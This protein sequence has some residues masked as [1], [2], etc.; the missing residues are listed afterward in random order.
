MPITFRE[1]SWYQNDA[2][3]AAGTRSV[4]DGGQTFLLVDH[5]ARGYQ[6]IQEAAAQ[7]PAGAVVLVAPGTYA[8]QV[9]VEGADGL[10]IRG[11]GAGVVI[12]CPDALTAVRS[13]YWGS[14]VAAVI[15][16]DDSSNVRIFNVTVDGA[17]KGDARPAGSGFAGVFFNNSS[18]ALVDSDVKGVHLQESHFG[19][20]TGMA[21][22]VTNDDEN[23]DNTFSA[24][25]NGFTDFQKAAIV[26]RQANVTISDNEIEGTHTDAIAQNGLDLGYGVTG[27][28]S[29]N[30]ITGIG[31]T[32]IDAS[33]SGIIVTSTATDLAIYGN[34][35]TGVSTTDSFVGIM[36]QT[37]GPGTGISVYGNSIDTAQ[38]GIY[39]IVATNPSAVDTDGPNGD[40]PNQVTNVTSGYTLDTADVPNITTPFE[41][42]GTNGNDSLQGQAGADR[43]NGGAGNDEI[44]GGAGDDVLT[45]G[46]GSDAIDGGGDVD[47]YYLHGPRDGFSFLRLSNGR[48]QVADMSG[49]SADI[50]ILS[51]V[52]R[53]SFNGQVSSLDDLLAE[54]NVLPAQAIDED[55]PWSFVVPRGVFDAAATGF[56]ATLAD[57]S[58]LPAWLSF[59]EATRTFSGTPPRNFNGSVSL[60]VSSEGGDFASSVTFSLSVRPVND[61]PHDITL[62]QGRVEENAGAGT[63]IGTLTGTDVDGGPLTF[64]LV[65]DAGGRFAIQNGRLVVKDSSRLDHEQ[66]TTHTVTIR[67]TDAANASYDETFLIEVGNRINET[68]LGSSSSDILKADAG[69]D[70]ISGAGG[71]D[72]VYGGFGHDS[73]RGDAG[74][75]V[76]VFDTK[77]S[78][79]ANRD[80]IADFTVR[81]DSL[82]LDNAVFT[83]LGTRGTD[84]SPAQLKSGHF[85]KGSAAKDKNDHV[86]YDAKKGVLLYDADGSGKGKAVEIATL[87]KHL[88]VTHKDFFVI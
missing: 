25:G 32:K 78:Q 48:V 38:Y 31:Y 23:K 10:T 8:E 27:D 20:Q 62:S 41:R 46:D 67:V 75:D 15:S 33:S 40:A 70:T 64:S 65:N 77:P 54:G 21:V 53:I 45:G 73:L 14:D 39:E 86:I 69:R 7:A 87:A 88:A 9:R 83:K 51:N 28:V 57:G 47:T 2:Q 66:A 79:S 42:T 63:P 80:K 81:D 85:V 60:K 12:T 50:D 22:V 55:S 18:G 24:I 36:L 29:G 26:V 1:G 76:F 34:T 56:V 3:I 59:D 82:W 17:G 71:D 11:A 58:A 30:T 61:A 6:T 49:G 35:I 4:E 19:V 5:A 52:E 84:A 74:R 68:V 44:S 72:T 13:D 37:Q 16:V 43:L